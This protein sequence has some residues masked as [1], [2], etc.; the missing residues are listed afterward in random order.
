M[1]EVLPDRY[2]PTPD[3]HATPKLNHLRLPPAITKGASDREG[4]F[5]WGH[6]AGHL[7]GGKWL[8]FGV[9]RAFYEY[10][11]LMMQKKLMW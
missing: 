10:I 2:S 4:A 5:D 1:V 11:M 8:T 9:T 6:L 7:T 3:H